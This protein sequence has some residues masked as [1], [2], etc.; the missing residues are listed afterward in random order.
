MDSC[1]QH[2]LT[3]AYSSTSG[4]IVV[5]LLMEEGL[6]EKLWDSIDWCLFT[7]GAAYTAGLLTLKRHLYYVT[8]PEFYEQNEK[9][10][11]LKAT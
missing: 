9:L 1:P 4:F 3:R 8:N 6:N 2:Q 11:L 7:C 10:I 5:S